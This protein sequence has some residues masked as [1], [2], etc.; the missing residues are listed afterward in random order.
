MK[1]F[2]E[3]QRARLIK[4]AFNFGENLMPYDCADIISRNFPSTKRGKY[5]IREIARMIIDM[6]ELCGFCC[7]RREALEASLYL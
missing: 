3:R 2:T 1:K 6:M 5:G 4:M 7:G